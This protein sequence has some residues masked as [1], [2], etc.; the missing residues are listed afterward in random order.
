MRLEEVR[1][2]S[3]AAEASRVQ[4]GIE[5][6]EN[7]QD[8]RE[9]ERA[10]ERDASPGSRDCSGLDQAGVSPVLVYFPRRPILFRRCPGSAP[11]GA[12]RPPLPLAKRPAEKAP[13]EVQDEEGQ[14]G[15]QG[16][17]CEPER[18]RR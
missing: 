13:E 2:A 14:A 7:E 10:R 6:G 15:E 17:A 9:G 16:A 4:V 8:S 1:A 11:R 5:D 12:D 18:H 3:L